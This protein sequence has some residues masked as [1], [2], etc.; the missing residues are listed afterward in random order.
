MEAQQARQHGGDAGYLPFLV[1]HLAL[2]S[3]RLKI[4]GNA[5]ANECKQREKVEVSA[6]FL[7]LRAQTLYEPGTI[8]GVP[9][10]EEARNGRVGNEEVRVRRNI[11]AHP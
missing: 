9:K 2:G 1:R 11:V 4:Y 10:R 5:L 8:G 7:Q 6:V 3:V